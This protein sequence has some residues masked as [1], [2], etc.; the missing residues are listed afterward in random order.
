MFS[1]AVLHFKE[2]PSFL[3]RMRIDTRG[4][5]K[6]HDGKSP[7]ETRCLRQLAEALLSLRRKFLMKRRRNSGVRDKRRPARSE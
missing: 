3:S 2:S 6:I 5:Q 7:A 4:I 1:A